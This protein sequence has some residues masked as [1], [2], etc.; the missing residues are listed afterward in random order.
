[1]LGALP[2]D[3]KYARRDNLFHSRKNVNIPELESEDPIIMLPKPV[4]AC[5]VYDII[6]QQASNK[7]L[8]SINTYTI[9]LFEEEPG[10]THSVKEESAPRTLKKES[11]S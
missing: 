11:T 1:M 7:R 3:I 5:V 10:S 2:R 9:L 8:K 6:T 4:N